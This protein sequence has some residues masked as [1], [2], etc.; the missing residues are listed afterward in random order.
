MRKSVRLTP[1]IIKLHPVSVQ[2]EVLLQMIEVLVTT[3]AMIPSCLSV[4]TTAVQS[5][6]VEDDTDN[7]MVGIFLP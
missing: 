2:Q 3:E 5:V 7:S 6:R 4:A 1:G